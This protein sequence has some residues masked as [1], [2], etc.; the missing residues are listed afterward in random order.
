M[1]TLFV[2]ENENYWRAFEFIEESKMVPV[3]QTPE[4]AKATAA[5]F[6]KFTA[7]FDDFNIQQLKKVIP[8]FHDLSLRYH[9]FEE[10]INGQSYER[11]ARALSLIDELKKGT[12]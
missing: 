8:G 11:I 1:T 6:A 2:D 3:A 12:L 7:T 4:Q 9:Q 5:T 10:A